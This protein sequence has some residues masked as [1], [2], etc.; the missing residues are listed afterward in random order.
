MDK[1][2]PSDQIA[3]PTGLT[4]RL[5]VSMPHL[6]DGPFE[7]SVVLIATHDCDHAFGIIV[8]KPIAGLFAADAVKDVRLSPAL[9][10]EEAP[11]YFG[12]PCEPQKGIVLHSSDYQGQDTVKVGND[13]ALTTS[14][15]ALERLHG[16]LLRPQTSRLL[17]G[18]AGWSAGQLDDELK[19]N[20]WLDL[21][22]SA[23][24]VFGQ[25]PETMWEAAIERIGITPESLAALAVQEPVAERPLN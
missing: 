13:L 9:T 11:V 12:G 24:F 21:P 17:A 10:A 7:K 19:R 15:D 1:V 18:H 3:A 22:A 6:N 14:K 2:T 20:F 23:E 25:S 4:G 8:N 5:L 16:D